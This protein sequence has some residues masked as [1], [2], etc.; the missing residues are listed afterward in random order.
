MCIWD[1]YV[2]EKGVLC[3][4]ILLLIIIIIISIIISITNCNGV[5]TW[6]SSPYTSTNKTNKNKC[7]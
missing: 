4:L 1:S 7:T 6:W 3:F 5:V 2:Y